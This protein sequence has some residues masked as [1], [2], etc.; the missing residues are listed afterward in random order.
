[1]EDTKIGVEVVFVLLTY[2]SWND[3][4]CFIDSAKKMCKYSYKIICV[5]SFYD[6]DSK[7][8][9][10]KIC[11]ANN[12]D[13]L[14]IENKG[15]GYGNNQGI[16]FANNKYNFDYL[17]I[18]NPD[19]EIKN[20]SL[21]NVSKAEVTAPKILTLKGKKQNPFRLVSNSYIE[22]KKYSD[23]QKNK[24]MFVIADI[25]INKMARFIYNTMNFKGE[26]YSCHGSFMILGCNV[27]DKVGSKIFNEKIFLFTE[28]DHVAKLM[29][30][31]KIKIR[32]TDDVEVLHKE[33]GSVKYLDNK[34]KKITRNSYIEYYNYWYK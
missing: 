33:D 27:I 8:E 15:Y 5:N 17:I 2:R 3:L 19:I 21:E 34:I 26:I 9:I 12:V 20:F 1:M 10:E 7:E 14:N 13:F 11:I 4:N 6:S 22:R 16:N 28:E 32:Y 24:R 31:N 30:R 23:F 29:E 25:V 18:S